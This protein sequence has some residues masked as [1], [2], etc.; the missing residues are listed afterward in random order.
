MYNVIHCE[1]KFIDSLQESSATVQV[2]LISGSRLIGR[3][4]GSDDHTILMSRVRQGSKMVYKSAITT[5]AIF[6]EKNNGE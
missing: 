4:L 3:I 1:Q 5:I 6:E 2:Y